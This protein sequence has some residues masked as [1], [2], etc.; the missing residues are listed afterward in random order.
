M[1]ISPDLIE[2]PVASKAQIMSGTKNPYISFQELETLCQD[3][4]TLQMCLQDFANLALRYAGTVCRFEQIVACGQESNEDG[5]RE[6]I[7]HVRSTIHN[8]TIE[9]I[10]I[11]SRNLRLFGIANSWIAKVVSGGRA[12]YGKFAI[13]IAFEIARR[14]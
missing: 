12:G 6:E 13:L 14:S 7:E 3:N 4:E 1:T 8:S 11:L 9:S 5:V 10:N 2:A